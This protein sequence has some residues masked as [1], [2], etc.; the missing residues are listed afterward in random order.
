[1]RGSSA[2]DHQPQPTDTDGMSDKTYKKL[3][4]A[5]DDNANEC[6]YIDGKAWKSKGEVT[7][8]ATDIAEFGGSEQFLFEHVHVDKAPADDWPDDFAD[9]QPST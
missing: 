9:L 6:L 3:T 8:Y 2:D 4:V 7:V 1:M 5:I